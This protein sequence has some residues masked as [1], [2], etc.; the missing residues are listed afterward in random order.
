MGSGREAQVGRDI[1]ILMADSQYRP[2][3]GPGNPL[4]YS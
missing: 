3:E 2:G 4:Q 1:G